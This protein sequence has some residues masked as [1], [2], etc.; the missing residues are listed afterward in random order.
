MTVVTSPA[1]KPEAGRGTPVS[2]D[3][4]RRLGFEPHELHF[5]PGVVPLRGGSGANWNT[6]GDIPEGPGLYAFTVEDPREANSLRVAYVGLST[7]LWM[8]TKGRLPAGGARGGQRYGRPKHAG[9]TRQRVNIEVARARATGLLVRHWLKTMTI[10]ET[11]EP[12]GFL[13][14]EEEDLIREWRLRDVGWNRG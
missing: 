11:V 12:R 13:R 2:E 1:F 9:D 8:V 10:P 14:Q 5:K 4:L 7:H 3:T 6:I